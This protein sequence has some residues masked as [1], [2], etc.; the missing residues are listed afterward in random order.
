MPWSY[1]DFAPSLAIPETFD[2]EIAVTEP[3]RLRAVTVTGRGNS[4][5]TAAAYIKVG[6]TAADTTEEFFYALLISGYYGSFGP[7]AWDGDLPYEV[8]AI[9][10]V[11]SLHVH[12]FAARVNYLLEPR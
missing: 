10:R 12:P 6:L 3:Q 9:L 2:F 1:R 11:R 7:L 5:W 8:G 4:L